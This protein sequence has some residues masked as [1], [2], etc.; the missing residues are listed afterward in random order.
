MT[1]D[2][3]I[4]WT[5]RLGLALLFSTAAWHKL[6]DRR[7]FEGTVRAYALLPARATRLFS[8]VLPAIEVAIAAALLHPQ[9]HRG[10]AWAAAVLLLLYT[11]AI[12]INLARGRRDIDCGCFR[13]RSATPLS[14]A[15]VVRNVALIAT[16]CILLIPLS[17]RPLFWM[18]SLTL[19]AAL[20]AMSLVWMAGQRLARTGP[21]L[22]QL[23]GPR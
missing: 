23:G 1:I 12:G 22:R 4:A 10:A 7:R 2:P 8:W 19:L 11:V 13:T 18:D 5:L 9:L 3:V 21:A 20:V 16:A 6:S 14:G 17:A 15:L